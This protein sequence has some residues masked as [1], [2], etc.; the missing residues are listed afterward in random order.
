VSRVMCIVQVVR[1]ALACHSRR[2]FVINFQCQPPAVRVKMHLTKHR[3]WPDK[4]LH[5]VRY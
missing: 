2:D 3:T 1:L 4:A 5:M